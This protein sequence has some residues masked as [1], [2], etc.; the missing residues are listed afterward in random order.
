ME[1]YYRILRLCAIV[2]RQENIILCCGPVAWRNVIFIKY[3]MLKIFH[4]K[5]FFLFPKNEK[6]FLPNL[7]LQKRKNVENDCSFFSEES[8][9]SFFW[10]PGL[11]GTVRTAATRAVRKPVRELPASSSSLPG[12]AWNEDACRETSMSFCGLPGMTCV[13]P[14]ALD[15]EDLVFQGGCKR[16]DGAVYACVP[17]KGWERSFFRRHRQGTSA[18]PMP[19]VPQFQGALHE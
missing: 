14:A 19:E 1:E 12:R 9:G 5:E 3:N 13:L 2:K 16:R 6:E 11:V 10:G 18:G 4:R 15:D 7:C 8:Q 17:C